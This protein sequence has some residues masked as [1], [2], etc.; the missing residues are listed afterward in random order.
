MAQDENEWDGSTFQRSAAAAT[1]SLSGDRTDSGDRRTGPTQRKPDGGQI[2]RTGG[3][4]GAELTAPT[5]DGA[6]GR[7]KQ[8]DRRGFS[9]SHRRDTRGWTASATAAGR[10]ANV[11]GR[12]RRIRGGGRLVNSGGSF[13]LATMNHS[14]GKRAT[15][16]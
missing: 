8:V 13:M 3:D 7:A 11:G 15:S 4:H 5:R 16:S 2:G 1:I 12:Q 6:E 10:R 14:S 9:R